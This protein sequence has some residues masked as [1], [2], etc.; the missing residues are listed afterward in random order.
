MEVGW[1]D[2]PLHKGYYRTGDESKAVVMKAMRESSRV[3]AQCDHWGYK[4]VFLH[5]SSYSS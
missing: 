5:I 2:W 1:E 4:I 3:P